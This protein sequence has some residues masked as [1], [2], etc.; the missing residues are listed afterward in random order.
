MSTSPKTLSRKTTVLAGLMTL[1]LGWHSLA[2]ADPTPFRL[3]IEPLGTYASGMFNQSAA[4]IVAHDTR[5]Q[6]L[7]VVSAV[8]GR[9][10][11][12]DIRTPSSPTL[13]FSLNISPWGST[14]NSVAVHNGVVAVA[15][16]NATRTAN[17][18][19]V[20]FDADGQ[21]LATVEVGALPDMLSFTPNG[22]HVL[23]ANE[24][25]PSA[26]YLTDPEGSVSIIDLPGDVRRL[27]QA[28]VR[29][30][31]F[32]KYN[33]ATLDPSIRIFGP[34]ARVAQDLEPE[35]ITVSHDSRTAWVT[36]QEA[37]AVA[38]LDIASGEFSALRGLG[39]KDHLLAGN[40]LDV[41]DQ[42]GRIAIQNWP[43]LGMYQPDAIAS[44]RY[45]GHT[46]L[47]TANEGDSR[48]YAGFSEESRFRAD[49]MPGVT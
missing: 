9:V 31:S 10:D 39:F 23:V 14:A 13:L 7:F 46:Y 4:E 37:N 17:S 11:V 29:T 38:V 5:T 24:G 15:V 8:Q 48:D 27:T 32:A 25:E 1:S 12:L 40:G 28:D 6:R 34:G 18:Q 21:F 49:V 30:A 44:Y 43:V 16:E 22:R 35:Y 20:F 42:D 3:S 45:Q 2:A 19:A 41:S 47:V 33:N 26:D 36:L